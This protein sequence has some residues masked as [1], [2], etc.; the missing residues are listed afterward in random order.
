MFKFNLFIIAA[1]YL[2]V[3]EDVVLKDFDF[4]RGAHL[5]MSCLWDRYE[6]LVATLRYEVAHRVYMPHLVVC[7]IF[8]DKSGVY[9]NARYM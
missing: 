5:R 2:G 9:I 3:C 6:E 4:N 1:W 7:I 8:A